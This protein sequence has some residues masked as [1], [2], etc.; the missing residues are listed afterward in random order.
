M[1]TCM[2]DCLCPVCF[3]NEVQLNLDICLC[4]SVCVLVCSCVCECVRARTSVTLCMDVCGHTR[5][6]GLWEGGVAL[7]GCV[8]LHSRHHRPLPLQSFLSPALPA[9]GTHTASPGISPFLILKNASSL[10]P[11]VRLPSVS[12]FPRSPASFSPPSPVFTLC[13]KLADATPHSVVR[14]FCLDFFWGKNFLDAE[15]SSSPHPISPSLS[16][17]PSPTPSLSNVLPLSP[18]LFLF[19]CCGGR[20][21]GFDRLTNSLVFGQS[22]AE[23]VYPYTRVRS[24]ISVFTMVCYK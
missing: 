15:G 14:H 11:P 16:F 22:W 5:R 23:Q 2:Y 18:P 13:V 24:V 8:L 9:V 20:P 3:F 1:L 10:L 7:R 21:A 17:P 6:R 4:V 19:L 12:L